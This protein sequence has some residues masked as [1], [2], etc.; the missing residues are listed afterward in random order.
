MELVTYV[1]ALHV[2]SAVVWAGGAF[3]MAWFVS[4][5]ARKAGP[6][7]GPFMGALASGSL[8]RVMTYASAATIAIGLV[9]W[10]QVVEGAP[11]GTRGLLLSIGAVAGF[12]ALGIGHGL[13]GPT[14]RKLAKVQLDVDGA[15]TPEQGKAMAELSGKM[16][17]YGTW[18]MWA[19]LASLATMTLGANWLG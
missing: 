2:I 11:T 9:L 10:A 6:A 18:L 14:A 1:S 15:P 17:T 16:A 19:L 8:S 12:V 4:P 3:I 13:Q 5:A 7:A